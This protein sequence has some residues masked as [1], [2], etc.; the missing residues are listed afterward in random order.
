MENKLEEYAQTYNFQLTIARPSIVCGRMLNAPKYFGS[1]YIVFYM[2]GKFF[3][4]Y[5]SKQSNETFR[6]L[7]NA[8]SGMNVVPVDYVATAIL[9]LIETNIKQINIVHKH[10]LPNEV[11]VGH[12]FKTSGMTNFEFVEEQ[13]TKH[14]SLMEKIYYKYV[15]SQFSNYLTLPIHQ[16]DNTAI[17][18]L[19]ADIPEPNV[20]AHFDKIY[21]YAHY[22]DFKN[23][24]APLAMA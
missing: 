19:M 13:P 16:Y 1:K 23:Q 17:R 8:K 7:V 20:T 3:K 22:R 6:L 10:N 14:L 9:R 18:E 4:D 5:I 12:I 24:P 2:F 11:L 15:G 21:N